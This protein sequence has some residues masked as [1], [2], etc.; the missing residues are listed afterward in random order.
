[1]L[2]HCLEKWGRVMMCVKCVRT[3]QAGIQMLIALVVIA[4]SLALMTPAPVRP[5]H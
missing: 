3:R 2:L 1:M 4:I 5:L